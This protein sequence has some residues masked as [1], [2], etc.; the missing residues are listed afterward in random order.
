LTE[1]QEELGLRGEQVG[2]IR[3]GEALRAYDDETDTVWVIHPFLFEARSKAIQL[4]WENSEYAW[5]DS[6]DLNSHPTVPKLKEVFDRV[7]R[8]LQAAPESLTLTLRTADDLA[9]DRVHGASFLG[10]KAVELLSATSLAS[11]AEDPD[12]LFSDLLLVALR[13]RK[14]QPGMAIVWN[15]VG[16]FLHLV[17]R[18]R[19]KAI[20]VVELKRTSVEIG[21]KIVEAAKE[22]SEDASRN[23]AHMLPQSG[24]V[25]THSYSSTVLRSL[26]LAMK[27]G[28]NFE[29][30]A[31]ESYPGMEGKKLAQ[32]LVALGIPVKLIPDSAVDSIIPTVDLVLV[33]ADSV[34]TDGALIH[35]T[36]TGTI[37]ATARISGIP[38]HSTCETMK[39]SVTNFLGENPEITEN[40]FDLTP[41]ECVADFI[42]EFGR[43]ESSRVEERIR[44]M[45]GEIY[46]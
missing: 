7:R 39:F 33:G 44:A 2:L 20:S 38:F 31:T 6:K 26:E 4:D 34:L 3:A 13:L 19:D 46:P 36:G 30:Y 32:D 22:A 43:V 9:R 16:R 1:I 40:L 23:S 27:S 21:E 45:V 28:K 29:V 42:T 11:K 25:L 37:A 15:L 10:R 12:E 35:K 17:D 8:D 14:A 24:R 5:I 18:E 41:S